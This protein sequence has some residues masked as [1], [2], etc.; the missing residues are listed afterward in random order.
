MLGLKTL[1]LFFLSPYSARI[2]A[3]SP[4]PRKRTS[5]S[6]SR[7]SFLFLLVDT[8]FFIYGGVP[9]LV[10]GAGRQDIRW[11][12]LV[13]GTYFHGCMP[14]GFRPGYIHGGLRFAS[15]SESL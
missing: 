1:L 14:V 9:L 11:V 3:I 7:Q 4:L 12:V 5:D 6:F 10:M 2:S 15:C 8:S 13:I